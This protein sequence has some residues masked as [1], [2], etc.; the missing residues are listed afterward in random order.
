MSK[1]SFI[2]YPAQQRV[3]WLTKLPAYQT[4]FDLPTAAVAS[5][6]DDAAMWAWIVRWAE[7]LRT[8]KQNLTAFKRQLRDGPAAPATIPPGAPDYPAPPAAVVADIFGRVGLLVQRIK[9]HPA[10]TEA[11]GRD[12][13][14]IAPAGAP[15]DPD[16]AQPVLTLSLGGRRPGERGLDQTGHGRPAHRGGPGTGRQFLAVDTAPLPP[17]RPERRVEI[18]RHL[19]SSTTRP[20][21]SGANPSASPC[22]GG[23]PSVAV[24]RILE[25]IKETRQAL[26]GS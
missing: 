3:T 21:A 11:V 10:Y 14:I 12:L 1:P 2:P 4:T 17:G 19:I 13:Q 5:V 22:W 7:A 6:A 20:R 24:R 16:T 9:N 25:G 8:R 15:T 23:D 26:T 18:P